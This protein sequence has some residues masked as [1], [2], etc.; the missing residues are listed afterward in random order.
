NRL[1]RNELYILRGQMVFTPL[2][3]VLLE[4]A[5]FLEDAI[6]F[7]LEKSDQKNLLQ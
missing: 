7:L 2:P 3:L 5:Y 6:Q 4:L 1:K